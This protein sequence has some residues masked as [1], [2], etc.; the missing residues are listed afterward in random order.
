[1]VK[2]TD[3]DEKKKRCIEAGV[4]LNLA[5][6]D[7]ARIEFEHMVLRESGVPSNDFYRR[8]WCDA[9]RLV[10]TSAEIFSETLISRWSRER[11]TVP[12][13]YF[14]RF[15]SEGKRVVALAK[16]TNDNDPGLAASSDATG[17]WQYDPTT[18]DAEWLPLK[19]PQ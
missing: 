13:W 5:L 4:K 17:F 12:G 16:H 11:P 1:M 18:D 3:G 6:A 8:E 7:L 14:V 2:Q 19:F 15:T 9:L 10:A